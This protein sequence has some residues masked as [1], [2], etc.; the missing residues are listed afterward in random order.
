MTA[1][2]KK[3]YHATLQVKTGR[4]PIVKRAKRSYIDVLIANI[5]EETA[6]FRVGDMRYA[7][8]T[9]CSVTCYHKLRKHFEKRF[10]VQYATEAQICYIS[11]GV[12]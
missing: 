12:S 2:E 11:K 3:I 8:V 6:T 10:L 5:E 7:Q 9:E 1:K 4:V